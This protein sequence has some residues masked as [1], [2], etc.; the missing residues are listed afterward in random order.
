MTPSPCHRSPQKNRDDIGFESKTPI[1][2]R[3]LSPGHWSISIQKR[4]YRSRISDPLIPKNMAHHHAIA[5]PANREQYAPQRSKC[6]IADS[7]S[8]IVSF[9]MDTPMAW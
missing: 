2:N 4:R 5:V 8:D 9:C 6:R 3:T 7:R 1:P